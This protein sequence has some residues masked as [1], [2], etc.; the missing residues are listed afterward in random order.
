LHRI[1]FS[2]STLTGC[3]YCVYKLRLENRKVWQKIIGNTDRLLVTGRFRWPTAAK[4]GLHLKPV[5]RFASLALPVR[6]RIG[7]K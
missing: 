4:L 7:P 1:F 3:G 6:R 5:S 2:A